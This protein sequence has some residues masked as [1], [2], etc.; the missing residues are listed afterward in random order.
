MWGLTS[1]SG[2]SQAD[3]QG[4][5][6]SE[7]LAALRDVSEYQRRSVG[8]ATV[9]GVSSEHEECPAKEE[10]DPGYARGLVIR[11]F[12]L[13]DS[14]DHGAVSHLDSQNTESQAKSLPFNWIFQLV[15]A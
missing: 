15:W 12:F 3:E 4:G 10:F 7:A 11:L 2:S 5:V 9:T 6:C 8:Y 1:P 13:S 14:S